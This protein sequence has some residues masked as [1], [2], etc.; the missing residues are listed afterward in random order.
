[1]EITF[2]AVFPLSNL[3]DQLNKLK[4]NIFAAT[5]EYCTMALPPFIPVSLLEIQRNRNTTINLIKSLSKTGKDVKHL[6][7]GS[8]KMAGNLLYLEIL[9]GDFWLSLN[10]LFGSTSSAQPVIKPYK[11]F[12]LGCLHKPLKKLKA[13]EYGISI[14]ESFSKFSTGIIQITFPEAGTWERVYWNFEIIKKN[15]R[16]W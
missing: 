8:L 6:K 9:T 10:K 12:F 1:M 3:K 7:T 11:G 14:P 13:Q 15:I 5:G 2:L 4:K 16:A